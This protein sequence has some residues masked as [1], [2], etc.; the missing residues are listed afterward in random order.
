MA[1][2]YAHQGSGAHDVDDERQ[3]H[4]TPHADLD[5]AAA[6]IV[7]AADPRLIHAGSAPGLMALQRSAGNAAV[8][9]LVAPRSVQRAVQIDELTSRVDVA[10]GPAGL[11][12]ATNAAGDAAANPVSSDGA[13][14][15]IT[16]AL[17][18]LD[19]AMVETGGII[20]ANTIVA[21]NVVG[22]NYTPG[23]GNLK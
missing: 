20:R 13:N 10:D 5:P 1:G 11:G 16:G 7:G 12:A 21:D 18:S 17:I 22:T 9:G 15:T 14:T 8:A 19:A 23:V 2:S 4:A 3:L 6:P